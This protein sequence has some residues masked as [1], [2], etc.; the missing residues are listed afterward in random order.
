MKINARQLI[1][2]SLALFP[3]MAYAN[4]GGSL[5][6]LISAGAFV[7]G[8]IWIL[9]V[10]TLF[11]K[12]ASGQSASVS[13]KQVFLANLCST[14][15]VGFG[16]PLCLALIT[17]GAM[18]LPAPYGGYA[19]LLGTWF[20][21]GAPHLEYLGYVSIVWLFITLLLTVLCEKAFYQRHWRKVGFVPE[22]SVDRF[23][24]Q[25]H[26]VSYSG[27]L[28]VVLVMWRELLF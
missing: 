2:I 5:L 15:V 3:A 19:S 17:L 1:T 16:L 22:F 13:F 21:E 4:G 7:Y 14:I 24:W 8:Q 9:L 10:E 20:Y 6:L 26:A 18:E 25:A 27:L 23:I 28:I 12:R 11:L